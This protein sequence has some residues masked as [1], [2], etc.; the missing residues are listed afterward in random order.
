MLSAM[1]RSMTNEI[2]IAK[3]QLESASITSGTDGQHLVWALHT[4]Q[5][6]RAELASG[7]LDYMQTAIMDT[8]LEWALFDIAWL[9][10]QVKP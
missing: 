3:G 2:E 8:R 6:A 9:T 7:R 10:G 5:W 1:H 4:A